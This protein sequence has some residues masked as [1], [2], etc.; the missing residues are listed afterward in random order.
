MQMMVITGLENSCY[1]SL[2]GWSSLGL[3]QRSK[4]WSKPATGSSWGLLQ[5]DVFLDHA[6]R[7][8]RRAW[9]RHQTRS[10]LSELVVA[11]KD[12]ERISM[13]WGKLNY[14]PWDDRK[15]T[16]RR[17]VVIHW[18]TEEFWWLLKMELGES[19]TPPPPAFK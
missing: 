4:V 6:R 9:G 13:D 8:I 1:S 14:L 17:E 5:F 7:K 18:I 12:W 11:K 3:R 2:G 15:G 10:Q 16:S 19:Q